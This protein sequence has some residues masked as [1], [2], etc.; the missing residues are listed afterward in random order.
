MTVFATFVIVLFLVTY[1]SV[2]TLRWFALEFIYNDIAAMWG[3]TL[4]NIMVASLLL[5]VAVAIGYFVARPFDQ[6]VKRIQAEKRKATKEEIYT[7]LKSYKGIIT[8]IIAANVIGFFI[9]QIIIV[10][11]GIANGSN[12]YYF[13]RVFLVVAQ[14]MGFGGISAITAI[15]LV[16]YL[17]IKKREMLEIGSIVEFRSR[18][19]KISISIGLV[20]FLSLYFLG[21]NMLCVPY[22]ILLESHNGTF[23]GDL[24]TAFFKKGALCIGLSMVIGAVPFLTV[25]HGL[26]QRIK[27]TSKLLDD[28]ANNGDLTCRININ[29]IDDFG[30]LISSVNTLIEKLSSMVKDLQSETHAVTES[31]GI[32]SKSARYATGAIGVM[33]HSL[34][35]IDENSKKQDELVAVTGENLEMLADSIDTVKL[36][37]TQ[38][39][40]AVQSISTAISKMTDSISSVAHTAKQAQEVSQGLSE[41]SDIGNAAVEHAVSTMKEIQIVSAEVRKLLKVIQGIASQTNLLSMNAAIEA[42]HA[43]EFGA[44]FAVVADEVRSLASSSSSSARDI[45]VKIKEMMEKTTA[46]V[47]AITSAGTAF[48]GIRDN[49][50]ENAALVKNIYDAMIAQNQGAADTKQ[51]ADELVEAIHAI[52]DLAEEETEGAMKLR[53]SM[54]AVVAASKS[55]VAAVQESME[56]TANMKVTVEKVD[57]SAEGN[58]ESVEKIYNHVEQFIV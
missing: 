34:Q 20:F 30:V 50:I 33:N 41:R 40:E 55:T 6:I 32:I 26:S 54:D 2:L 45:Q 38:Q 18:S 11:I 42:A 17:L 53:E 36:H 24:L 46:G 27:L 56:A 25:L 4:P 35:H 28:I 39:T 31:A 22:G 44:G 43:G 23:Q 8:L 12:V 47:E 10:Y 37:V 16:D 14:A 58:K 49:V 15:K 19:S 51:A 52:R 13:S 7:C 21:I 29:M 48:Q 5:L 1:A 3:G 9:G 57:K